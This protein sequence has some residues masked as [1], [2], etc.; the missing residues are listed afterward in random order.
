MSATTAPANGAVRRGYSFTDHSTY[1]PNTPPP[2]D[3]IDAELDRIY[4]MVAELRAR[5][6]ELTRPSEL[7][8]QDMLHPEV[9][10]VLRAGARNA[11]QPDIDRAQST[12]AYAIAAADR[13]NKEAG[14]AY[15]AL[16]SI[17]VLARAIDER[18]T[19]DARVQAALRTA[20]R[21]AEDA[22]TDA[23]NSANHAALSEA[24][25]ENEREL[26]GAWAEYL[27]GGSPIPD[28]FFAH[29]AITGQHWSSR[30]WALKAAGAFGQMS[31]LYLGAHPTPPTT[32][33]TGDPI[34]LGAIYYNT[35]NHQTYVWDGS[36]WAPLTQP[37]I[38]SVASL[39]Y[40]ATAGQSDFDT[41]DPD[42]AGSTHPMSSVTTLDV[43]VNGVRALIDDPPGVGD[44]TVDKINS[45]IS[46]TR[47]LLQGSIVQIDVVSA[48][49]VVAGIVVVVS[50]LDFDI[51]PVTGN[52]GQIDGTRKVF[53]LAL[54]SDRTPVTVTRSSDVSVSVDG[55]TQQPDRDYTALDTSITFTEAPLP[56]ARA[57][58]IWYSPLPLPARLIVSDMPT[59]DPHT[60]DQL[61]NNGGAVM[62][63]QG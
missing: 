46:F 26:A 51:D 58:G 20:N 1:Q 28:M 61:W 12:L 2:G 56:G 53:P 33:S 19:T 4:H 11:V 42:L 36:G 40:S 44:Y 27:E 14:R 39:A 29:T 13:A 50:L 24:E 17:Q 3:R 35:T 6:T 16:Q 57:W 23:E 45:T 48:V 18:A 25:A 60:R 37:A 22:A 41:R 9:L 49:T 10:T 21:T 55:V 38:G 59:T 5:V 62:V 31:E 63:S 34:P 47:P 8:T 43:H 7:I 54:A 32:T 52:P 30:W 15:L